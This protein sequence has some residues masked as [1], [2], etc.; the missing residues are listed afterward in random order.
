MKSFQLC[1]NCNYTIVD[2]DRD[3]K[4]GIIIKCRTI[5]IS[6]EI[7]LICPKCKAKVGLSINIIDRLSD[8]LKTS[9]KKSEK[10]LTE[11]NI[12]DI[13]GNTET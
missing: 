1:P 4:D 10:H 7:K 5:R 3:K 2:R 6:D 13:V 9:I 12:S 8:V 11:L